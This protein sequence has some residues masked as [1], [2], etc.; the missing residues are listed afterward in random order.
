MVRKDKVI[1]I[2]VGEKR[3][4]EGPAPP[5]RP[6]QALFR[7]ATNPASYQ[8]R[9]T[10]SETEA[11]ATLTD[12]AFVTVSSMWWG[13]GNQALRDKRTVPVGGLFWIHVPAGPC[14]RAA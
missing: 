7:S 14:T 5:V 13:A 4:D 3:W 10:A 1:A 8:V 9:F 11:A 6:A 12:R 2:G